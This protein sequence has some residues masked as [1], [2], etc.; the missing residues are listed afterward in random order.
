MSKYAT[1][2]E[3]E[4]WSN[5]VLALEKVLGKQNHKAKAFIAVALI[6][7]SSTSG[8]QLPSEEDKACSDF[9]TDVANFFEKELLTLSKMRIK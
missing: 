8:R 6:G 9:Y 1:K 2:E 4:D 5:A 3:F 7:C